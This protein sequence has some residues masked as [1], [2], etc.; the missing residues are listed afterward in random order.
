MNYDKVCEP[1]H[2]DQYKEIADKVRSKYISHKDVLP[3]MLLKENIEQE[4]REKR[5]IIPN[6]SSTV[7]DVWENHCTNDQRKGFESLSKK[8]NGYNRNI[9]NVN[10]DSRDRMVRIDN[11]QETHHTFGAAIFGGTNFHKKD[12]FEIYILTPFPPFP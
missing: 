12:N 10:G 11:H 6:I 2:I 1:P 7:K 4:V 5:I 3:Q 9:A 8:V